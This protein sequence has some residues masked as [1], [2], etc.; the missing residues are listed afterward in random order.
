VWGDKK[1][2]AKKVTPSRRGIGK[3]ENENAEPG[4]KSSERG[5]S[6]VGE[7]WGGEKGK[8]MTT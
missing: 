4:G 3:H 7:L 2:S 5:T 6:T 1:K 8:K